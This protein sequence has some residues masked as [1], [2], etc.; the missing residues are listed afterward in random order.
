MKLNARPFEH[1]PCRAMAA[2]NEG[3]TTELRRGRGENSHMMEDKSLLSTAL[4]VARKCGFRSAHLPVQRIALTPAEWPGLHD[5]V[6]WHSPP[7]DLF[8]PAVILGPIGLTTSSM[9]P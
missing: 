1:I 7:P 2:E 4:P 3:E 6:L 9:P 5:D 8:I